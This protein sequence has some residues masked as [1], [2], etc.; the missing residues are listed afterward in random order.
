MVRPARARSRPEEHP[1]P[2]KPI[3]RTQELAADQQMI[4]GLVKHQS[5]IPS[6]VL[7]TATMQNAAM[8]Q[9]LQQ[10][11][12][13]AKASHVGRAVARATTWAQMQNLEWSSTPDTILASEP[14]ASFTPPTMSICHNSIAR[15]RSHRL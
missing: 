6:L 15:D 7:G 4:D 11:I 5:D 9:R 3:N 8:V 13:N 1:H 12:A 14:S 2:M 10:R